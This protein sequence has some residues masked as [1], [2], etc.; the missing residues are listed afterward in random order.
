M[1]AN[2]PLRTIT[3]QTKGGTFALV[4]AFLAKHYGGGYT[5][6]GVNLNTPLHSITTK[7]HHSLVTSNL[8]KLR[9]NNT[10]APV[11]EP[12]P[13]ITAGGNH[14]G[15]VRA[16]LLKYYGTNIGHD[17]REPLQT[18]TTKHRFGLVTIH[19]ENYQI[20]DIGMR[21]LE[22]HE[23]Y[24]AQS[25]PDDYKHTHTH[26]GKKLSKAA[27]VRMCGNS[28]CPELARAI[29]SANIEE[30]QQEKAA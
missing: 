12:V 17:A 18:I 13:T 6:A 21:M 25:F 11:T 10:G 3:A 30:K 19:G 26:D 1:A 22:P 8:I 2:E 9:N 29:V 4:S 28:V 15:E 5:G 14:I 16:F 23:L 7:D 20:V 24:I 27:Q